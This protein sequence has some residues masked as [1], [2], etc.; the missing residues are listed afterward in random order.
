MMYLP[1]MVT[2]ETTSLD[3]AELVQGRYWH[4]IAFKDIRP[5]DRI[6]VVRM[7]SGVRMVVESVVS[8]FGYD[9][10]VWVNDLDAQIVSIRDTQI[11]REGEA[12]TDRS[13]EYSDLVLGD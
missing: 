5:G 13:E 2:P 9:K 4:R 7:S 10:S 11:F 12:R 8:R 3:L 1:K 6:L